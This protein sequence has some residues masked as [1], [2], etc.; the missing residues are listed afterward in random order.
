MPESLWIVTMRPNNLFNEPEESPRT[1]SN[2]FSEGIGNSEVDGNCNLR[3][4]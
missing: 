4:L 3:S 1:L 2:I